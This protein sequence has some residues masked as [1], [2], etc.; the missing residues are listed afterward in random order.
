MLPRA[1]H[2]PAE[3]QLFRQDRPYGPQSTSRTGLR[4][5]LNLSSCDKAFRVLRGG[6]IPVPPG[7][8]YRLVVAVT[9]VSGD[10][11]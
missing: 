3:R 6:C 10:G 11:L 1:S 8:F 4:A 5:K 2:R 7:V 9:G